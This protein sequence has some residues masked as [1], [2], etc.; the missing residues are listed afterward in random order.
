[1]FKATLMLV[2]IVVECEYCDVS[3]GY[4]LMLTLRFEDLAATRHYSAIDY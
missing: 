1:M 4:M 2:R 3:V